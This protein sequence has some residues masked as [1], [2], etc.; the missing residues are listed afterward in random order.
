MLVSLQ[1]FGQHTSNVVGRF[2]AQGVQERT[3]RFQREAD[4]REREIDA[5]LAALEVGSGWSS[6][7]GLFHDELYYWACGQ[8][9]GFGYVDQSFFPDS[10]R[11]QFLLDYWMPRGTHIQETARDTVKVED[12]LLDLD[13]VTHVSTVIGEG[14]MRFILTYAAEK[15]DSGYAQ[16]MV[17]V[18]DYRKIDALL[19]QNLDREALSSS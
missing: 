6:I 13:G 12:Y 3:A 15:N 8:R 2:V 19:P 9:P 11:P 7:Y 1:G 10:T 4:Q 18:D 17:D 14:A 16:F 5:M